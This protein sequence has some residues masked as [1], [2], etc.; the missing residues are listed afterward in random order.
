MVAQIRA[1]LVA[2]SWRDLAITLGPI[3]LLSLAGIWFAIRFVRPA[4]PDSITISTG[5]DGSMYRIAA[6]KYRSILASNG[7]TLKILP[8]EGSVENLRR[9]KQRAQ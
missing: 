5:P 3:L 1:R 9:L 4:P 7:I 6:D 2:I 8:S